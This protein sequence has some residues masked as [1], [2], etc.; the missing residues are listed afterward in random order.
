MNHNTA[1]LRSMVLKYFIISLNVSHKDYIMH[2]ELFDKQLME[3][4]VFSLCKVYGDGV[5]H[6]I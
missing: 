2:M 1:Y 5:G 6:I 3:M 4:N